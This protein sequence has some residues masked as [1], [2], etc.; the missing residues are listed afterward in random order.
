MTAPIAAHRPDAPAAHLTTATHRPAPEA[1]R[2]PKRAEDLIER[3]LRRERGAF[4]E[5]VRLYQE[6]MLK[7]ALD[8]VQDLAAAEEVVQDTWIGVLRG[9]HRFERRASFKTWLF[10]IL[11]N[12]ARTRGKRDARLVSFSRVSAEPAVIDALLDAND[13]GEHRWSAPARRDPERDLR[14]KQA[15]AL[16][17][18]ALDALPEQQRAVV[19]MRDLE[20]ADFRDICDALQ[21][22]PANQRVLL[23]RGRAR[24]RQHL[25]DNLGDAI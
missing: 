10:R 17:R 4:E 19:A 12:R 15:R 18:D 14:R 21:I 9:L 2:P 20:D 25:Q 8:F 5:V 23:H 13:D 6:P 11:L 7:L 3:L 22:S 24:L 1:L 16:L